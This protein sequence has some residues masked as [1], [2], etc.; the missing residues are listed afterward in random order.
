MQGLSKD[1]DDANQT[2]YGTELSGYAT[3][4]AEYTVMLTNVTKSI[5]YHLNDRSARDDLSGESMSKV[6]ATC[7]AL[8][9]ARIVEDRLKT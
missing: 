5:S 8:G 2:L 1:F 9:R 4:K 7:C 3:G 6:D